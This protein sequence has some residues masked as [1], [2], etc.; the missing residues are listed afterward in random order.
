MDTDSPEFKEWAAKKMAEILSLE[1]KERLAEESP[2]EELKE[3]LRVLDYE[4]SPILD[5]FGVPVT[6]EEL[7]KM[8]AEWFVR[9]EAAPPQDVQGN[10]ELAG[11]EATRPRHPPNSLAGRVFSALSLDR[12]GG[13]LKRLLRFAGIIIMLIPLILLPAYFLVS[14]QL[15]PP[16]ANGVM[17]LSPAVILIAPGQTQNY[18]VLTVTMPSS[19]V[20]VSTTLAAVAPEGLSFEISN[21]YVPPQE[22]AEIPVVI[23]ASSTLAPGPYKVTVKETEGS[24]VRD[25]TFN[26]T[27]V[28]ALVVMEHLAFVPHTVN[29]AQGTTVYWMNLDSMIGCC[30][31]GLH[32]ADF[33]TGMKLQ[34][35]N[36]R[37]F[38]TWSFQFE[39]AGDF[40][41]ICS[42]HPF[43][44]GEVSVTASA[45]EGRSSSAEQQS[46]PSSSSSASPPPPSPN[47]TTVDILQGSATNFSITQSYSPDP[48]TV[49][50]G[51]NN[52][53]T[54]VNNDSA[55]HT[56]TAYDGSF[57]SG[58]IAPAGTFTFTFTRPGTYPYYCIYH[59]WMF[60]T[61]IVKAG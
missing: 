9:R 4:V 14:T 1:E 51:V 15:P 56:V 33:T 53:V 60:G 36:L 29:V 18:S 2:P 42:I 37:T 23:H 57:D 8:F 25:Q 7:A 39:N 6:R 34:S 10:L 59:S 48:V 46:A 19:N 40:Y 17:T 3:I 11:A 28:P 49:V 54:W 20:T 32:N 47:A 44:T 55:P 31:P 12:L 22:T 50:V 16:L 43:M 26:I 24:S 45:N 38:D 30:D 5:A 35:P 27:V 61:V 21:T 13:P 41:Y 58:N 52:T